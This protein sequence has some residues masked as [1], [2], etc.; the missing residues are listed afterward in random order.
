MFISFF[1]FFI[2]RVTGITEKGKT[3]FFFLVSCHFMDHVTTQINFGTFYMVPSL[4]KMI[5]SYF[6]TH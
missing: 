5:T 6:C 3:L 4:S 2:F 1:A